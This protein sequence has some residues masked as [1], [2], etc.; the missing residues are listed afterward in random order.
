MK[1]K[2]Y[3][4][5]LFLFWSWPIHPL[6]ATPT[7][8]ERLENSEKKIKVLEARLRGTRS[9]VKENRSR[10]SDDAN[11]LR[12]NGFMS[13][14]IAVNDGDDII[15]PITKI[16]D[17]YSSSA[18][19]K[20]GIQFDFKLLENMNA[21]LQLISKGVN[22]YQV[23]AEWAYLNWQFNENLQVKF[24]RQRAP[25]YM[26]SE[27]LDVG[28]ALPWTIAPLEMYSLTTTTVDGVSSTYSTRFG[29]AHFQWL[30]Y[31]GA[32]QGEVEDQELSFKSNDALGTNVQIEI[33]SW[34]FRVGYSV[35]H[36]DVSADSG[37]LTDQFLQ[38]VSGAVNE[39]GPTYNVESDIYFDPN[40]QEIDAQYVNAGFT[41]DNGNLLIMGEIAN[42]RLENSYQS[43][44][45]SGYI[46]VGYRFGKW[47]PHITFAKY[48]TDSR[49]DSEIRSLQSYLSETA[50]AVYSSIPPNTPGL[51]FTN[52]NINNQIITD[53]GLPGGSIP[54][55]YLLPNTVCASLTCSASVL[56][57]LGIRDS[58]VGAA[59]A[60]GE[61]LYNILEQRVQ[62]QQSYSIGVVYDFAPGV[63]A[64]LQVTHYEQFGSNSY[65][66]LDI[67]SA[68]FGGSEVGV[69]NDFIKQSADGNGRFSGEPGSIKNHTAIYSFS[70][71]AVF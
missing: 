36:L 70:V 67:Q 45:N 12:I 9:A 42:L 66:Y 16:E 63:K 4:I 13:T 48:Q 53:N 57:S 15:E 21:V 11:R 55:N 39:I 19:S 17:D 25:F 49:S 28:Y 56:T 37:G 71:D 10:I 23:E 6:F 65:Q 31:A 29:S 38:G 46:T 26:L 7:I 69:L 58:L 44:G 2:A 33:D 54:N 30:L 8:E 5:S 3:W 51:V 62:E 61:T 59:T 22:D 40:E 47:M 60:Y 68:T 41:Y 27:F 14:G 24:G 52:S 20:A 18:I 64:K 32:S 35:G 50:S 43:A 34:L 1:K